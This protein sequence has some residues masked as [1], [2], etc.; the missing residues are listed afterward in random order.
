LPVTGP[1]GPAAVSVA[2]F[3]SLEAVLV[4]LEQALNHNNPHAAKLGKTNF[5]MVLYLSLLL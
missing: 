2:V 1:V 3:S 4:L 5:F